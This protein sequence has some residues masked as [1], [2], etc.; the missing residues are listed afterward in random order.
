MI[1]ESKENYKFTKF[2]KEKKW[3]DLKRKRIKNI[4]I[5]KKKYVQ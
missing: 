2:N 3:I 4:F 5:K 1:R